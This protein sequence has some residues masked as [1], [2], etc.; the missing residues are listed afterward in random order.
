MHRIRGASP[1][2]LQLQIHQYMGRSLKMGV[3]QGHSLQIN[4]LLTNSFIQ[5]VCRWSLCWIL[6]YSLMEIYNDMK[7]VTLYVL[8]SKLSTN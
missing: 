3:I 7:N 2:N 6:W 4:L 1:W 5:S 8:W